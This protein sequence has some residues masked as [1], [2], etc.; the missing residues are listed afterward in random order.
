MD[1]SAVL[2]C[3]LCGATASK[4]QSLTWVLEFDPR[5]GRVLTCPDC[6][7]RYL[8]SIEAKLDTEYW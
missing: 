8:R 3:N 2:R 6:A 1:D 4:A 7:R 5:R